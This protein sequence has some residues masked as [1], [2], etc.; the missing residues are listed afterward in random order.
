MNR[1]AVERVRPSSLERPPIAI[2][3]DLGTTNSLMAIVRPPAGTRTI[4]CAEPGGRGS[5]TTGYVPVELLQLAQAYPDGTRVSNVLF[6]SVVYQDSAAGARY[7]GAG[8]VDSKYS[9]RRG[10]RV[11]YSVKMDMGSDMKPCYPSAVSAEL[12]D[13]VKVSAVILQAMRLAA[14]EELRIDLSSVP[15]IV[16]IPASFQS[17]Q[18][19]DTLD[20]ASLAGLGVGSDSLFDEPIA[21]LLG[22]MNRQRTSERWN[23]EESVLVF[24]F[25]GGTC[26]VTI[27]EAS[28][29]PS[30][31][32]VNL[33]CR[34]IS[35]FEQLGGDDI[36]RHMVHTFLKQEF[37]GAAKAH[38]RDFALADRRYNI[39][40]QLAKLAEAL[41]VRY[42]RE[43]HKVAPYADWAVG[44]IPPI[45]VSLPSEPISSRKGTFEIADI[46]IDSSLFSEIM[47]P[48]V[49]PSSSLERD[50]EYYRLTSIFRPISDA[51]SKAGLSSRDIT[52]VL[53]AGGS[54]QNPIIQRALKDYFPEAVVEMPE[55]MDTLVVE[56]AAVHAYTRYVMGHDI[57]API[58]GDSIGMMLEGGRYA[59]LIP[60]GSRVPFPS[61]DGWLPISGFRLPKANMP[62]VDIVVCAGNASR[63]VHE[64]SL[65]LSGRVPQN[66]SLDVR[67]RMDANKILALEAFLPEYPSLRVS[68]IVENPLGLL[69]MTE[70]QRERHELEKTLARA[71]AERTLDQHI[72][73]MERLAE[74]LNDLDRAELALDWATRAES[75]R[76]GSNLR[77]RHIRA[78]A[79]Y[80]LG[81][82]DPAFELY[83][84]LSD[85]DVASW[86]NALWACRTAPSLPLREE[87]AER[88]RAAGPGNGAVLYELAS[89]RADKGDYEGW[90]KAMEAARDAFEKQARYGP[91][92][93]YVYSWLRM[94]YESLGEKDKA[95]E[96]LEKFE[97]L[98]RSE[99]AERRGYLPDTKDPLVTMP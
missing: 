5:G 19:K 18:R 8:A 15:V 44:S 96:S 70:E 1:T 50:C 93:A 82:R 61:V 48:F 40:S 38:E 60:A 25:G 69:P 71:Q 99:G 33:N 14:E 16:T 72:E 37:Y 39:W 85:E 53:L 87:Y 22:Y 56:G 28:F 24:D 43:L 90:R 47:A 26:D 83:R 73:E 76:G 89:V 45:R 29:A 42:C 36:D 31:G 27:V 59:P 6:P 81:E 11:F 3:I 79:H 62:A 52:R 97:E 13:P 12:D 54:S 64:V 80:L 21:A 63:P 77:A 4:E 46:S 68:T 88:A 23:T 95:R 98:S 84:A 65:Q 55:D 92:A 75:Y 86:V 78:R 74:L 57:L 9:N 7:V 49:D 51:L 41:K 2:G 58:L 20:A 91:P 35:R 32:A 94:V 30:S 34:S 66:A 10:H 67:V 17:P